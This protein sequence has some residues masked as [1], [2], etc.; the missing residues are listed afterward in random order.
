VPSKIWREVDII[1]L[2]WMHSSLMRKI[3]HR[4]KGKIDKTQRNGEPERKKNPCTKM[5]RKKK[6]KKEKKKKR[7]IVLSS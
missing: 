7:G 5:R 4:E 1:R 3:L 6:R 2:V